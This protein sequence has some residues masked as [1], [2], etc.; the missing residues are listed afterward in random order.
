MSIELGG[1]L[2]M[3]FRYKALHNVVNGVTASG[4]VRNRVATQAGYFG[5]ILPQLMA[6]REF[7]RRLPL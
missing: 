5:P 7:I 2:K 1:S 3:F 4:Q 6:L